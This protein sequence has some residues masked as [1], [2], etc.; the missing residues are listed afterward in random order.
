MTDIFNLTSIGAGAYSIVYKTMYN[1]KPSAVKILNETKLCNSR[2]LLEL[3]MMNTYNH[4]YLNR[5]LDIV[6][7]DNKV[8]IYQD[9]ATCDLKAYIRDNGKIAPQLT[10]RWIMQ[11]CTALSFLKMESIVHGDVKPHNILYYSSTNSVKLAD[12]GCSV[13]LTGEYTHISSGTIRYNP[14]ELLLYSRVSFGADVWSLGCM[15]YEMLTGDPLIPS[16]S[17]AELSRKLR[18]VKSIQIWRRSLGDRIDDELN[19]ITCL[20]VTFLIGGNAGK[21][22]EKMTAYSVRNRLTLEEVIISEW[23]E[24]DNDGGT[25]ALIQRPVNITC[26]MI[27]WND[28]IESAYEVDNYLHVRGF[29]IPRD[30]RNKGIQ[31]YSRSYSKGIRDIEAAIQ[32]SCALFRHTIESYHPLSSESMLTEDITRI[33]KESEY[34]LHKIAT[35]DAYIKIGNHI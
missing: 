10:K 2:N 7:E 15:I 6:I 26:P 25:T 21:L 4:P 5:A 32:I 29:D 8:L 1:N 35:N 23:L 12:F 19:S 9:I 13:I 24:S 27:N 34:R 33:C 11:V 20:P 17:N 22:I 30:V 14:P 16:P 28:I 31:I 18:T 3:S